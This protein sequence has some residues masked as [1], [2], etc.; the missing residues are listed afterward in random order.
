MHLRD[1]KPGNLLLDPPKGAKPLSTSKRHPK[2]PERL[3]S[4]AAL[5]SVADCHRQ[6][7]RRLRREPRRRR[8]WFQ[9]CF[10][11]ILLSEC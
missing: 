6:R 10:L 2:A 5:G 11:C 4:G 9:G 7:V 8:P 1:A 3:V